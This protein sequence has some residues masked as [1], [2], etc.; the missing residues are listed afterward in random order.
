MKRN[1]CL[2]LLVI[3]LLGGCQQGEE[4]RQN[5]ALPQPAATATAP[6]YQNPPVAG[7]RDA[8]STPTLQL[9]DGWQTVAWHGLVIP[10]PPGGR[11]QTIPATDQPSI[12][13]AR[14]IAAGAIVYPAS[15]T[16]PIEGPFGP[17]FT[18]L[19]FSGSLEEWVALERRNSPAGNPLQ[20]DTIRDI[21]IA[22]RPAKAYQ[23]AVTGTGLTE[24]YAVNLTHDQLLL[25]T[26]DDAENKMYRQVID[27][28]LVEAP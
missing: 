6:H 9:P 3:G 24:Y 21:T 18:M 10:V 5:S 8:P 14:V 7:E 15:T 2:A 13:D 26:T 16:T 4:A 17:S 19:R 11:W 25:I 12:N 28:L 20:E 1:L 27:G 22:G 23:H